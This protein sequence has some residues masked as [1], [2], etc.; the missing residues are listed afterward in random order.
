MSKEQRIEI[1]AKGRGVGSFY[2]KNDVIW[3]S[4]SIDGK[5]YRKST[6]KRAT[7]LNV[8]WCKNQ[9]PVQ[10][11]SKILEK[12]CETRNIE[13]TI[14]SIGYQSLELKKSTLCEEVYKDYLYIFEKLIVSYFKKFDLSDVK[15]IDIEK[16]ETQFIDLSLDR[17]QRIRR[18]LRLIFKSA[19]KNGLIE[20][21]P[22]EG[23]DPLKRIKKEEAEDSIIDFSEV[24]TREEAEK[25]VSSAEHP[26]KAFVA[27]L[28]YT[29]MRPGE[30]IGLKWGDIDFEKR[31]IH[32]KRSRTKGKNRVSNEKK[33]HNRDIPVI[34]K[35]FDILVEYSEFQYKNVVCKKTRK[36]KSGYQISSSDYVFVNSRNQAWFDTKT[37][38][39]NHFKP[40]LSKIGVPYKKLKNC[41]T[42]FASIL[43]LNG[44]DLTTVQDIIGHSRDSQTLLRHYL[45]QLQSN[46]KKFEVVRN[47]F[48]L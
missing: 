29:G 6:G 34:D 20:H 17:R 18:V 19:F 24:Y 3:V 37:I 30:A 13:Y 43:V 11:L 7:K 12:E 48:K 47:A 4:G 14:E 5:F 26:L 41:R 28:F 33:N 35:L 10:I 8:G 40:H 45:K 44:V 25:I 22:M 27:A 21:N 42:T 16:F 23:L 38:I 15:L 46:D 1:K 32:L 31:V 39:K 36:I 2:V 9:V